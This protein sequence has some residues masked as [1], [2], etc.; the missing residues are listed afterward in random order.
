MPFTPYLMFDGAEF[1]M[2]L[3]DS[4]DSKHNLNNAIK[5]RFCNICDMLVVDEE[6][7]MYEGR[8]YKIE[9]QYRVCCT[10]MPPLRGKN[11]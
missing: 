11:A 10:P 2:S 9:E 3:L 8:Q 4:S 7:V 5:A 1:K 6:F